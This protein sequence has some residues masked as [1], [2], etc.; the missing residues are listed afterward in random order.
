MRRYEGGEVKLTLDEITGIATICLDHSEKKNCLSGKMMVELNDAMG[1]LEK[2]QRGKGLIL[3]SEGDMFCSGSFLDMVKHLA[4][5]PTDG[6][7]VSCLMHDSAIRL[8]NLPMISVA[9]VQGLAL[10]GGAE[11][12]LATDF[13]LF[14]VDTEVAYIQS[15]MGITTAWGG[16][17]LLKNLIGHAKALDLLLTGRKVKMEEAL[18]IGLANGTVW[19]ESRLEDAHAWLTKHIHSLPASVVRATKKNILAN[20]FA[21]ERQILASLWGGPPHLDALD[22]DI[23]HDIEDEMLSEH[24]NGGETGN[25]GNHWVELE[26]TLP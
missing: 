2:W 24:G 17:M 25:G 26:E 5:D 11:L 15:K 18:E 9:V 14:T 23:K 7:R 4:L 6:Y 12:L 16:G 8:R 21:E 19:H 20:S 13:R 10:G 3:Y 22:R 1:K